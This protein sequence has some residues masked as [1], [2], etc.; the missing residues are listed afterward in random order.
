MNMQLRRFLP[1]G[2]VLCIL[3]S[4]LLAS[5]FPAQGQIEQGFKW[6][7]NAAIAL[8]FFMHGAKLSRENIVAGL[9]HWRLHALIFLC[10]FAFF[11]LLSILFRPAIEP[12]VGKEL[13]LGV[14]YLCALPS[15]VQSAIAFTS[16]ARGNVPAA[17][18]SAAASSLLGIFIT[19]LLVLW[20][21]GTQGAA[22]GT[23]MLD[24]IY[25][26]VMQLLVPFIA[27]QVMRR[28][29]GN[30]VTKNKSLIKITDQGSILLVVYTAFGDAVNDGL[31][32]QVSL[33]H[34]FALIAVCCVLLAVALVVVWYGSKR[35]GFDLE[36]RITILFCGSK[37][38][39]A[40]G[41]PM[42]QVLFAGGAI[43][44]MILPV[45]LFH[46]IQLLVCAYLAQRFSRREFKEPE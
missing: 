12:L 41:V 16:L 46:Q 2:F 4:V 38:S 1:D 9:S 24:V 3:A 11:P 13:A 22:D 15:T 10:T 26:I 36:D 37:K 39:L 25:K 5:I 31:W 32:S 27:G 23:S 28:W 18:C 45:M 35:M 42:A 19:P 20:L 34:L 40:S 8:L 30:W 44:M 6:L 33:M 29:I 21:M 43:G 14:L 7:T 17:I